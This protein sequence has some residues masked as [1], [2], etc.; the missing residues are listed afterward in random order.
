MFSHQAAGKDF[1]GKHPSFNNNL[2]EAIHS[3]IGADNLTSLISSK[4]DTARSKYVMDSVY[5]VLSDPKKVTCD[6]GGTATTQQ[7]TNEVIETIKQNME[8]S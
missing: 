6:L 1:L 7:F 2:L 5:Q 4:I 3:E 8:I